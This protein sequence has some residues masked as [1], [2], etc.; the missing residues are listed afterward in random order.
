[1]HNIHNM[2]YLNVFVSLV[3]SRRELEELLNAKKFQIK[4]IK[5]T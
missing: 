1:M 3:C 4:F 2:H 5:N